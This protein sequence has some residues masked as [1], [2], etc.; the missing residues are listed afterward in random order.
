[1]NPN[2]L[3]RPSWVEIDLDAAA[4]NVAV[5]RRL[6]GATVK[7]Y[8]V[9]KA[10]AMGCGLVPIARTLARSGVDALAVSDPS[11]VVA[12]R[13][14]G[15]S[16]PVLLFAST[17][18]EQAADVAALDVIPAI[19][20]FPSLLAFAKLGRPLEVFFKIDSGMGRLGFAEQQWEKV[21]AAAADVPQL[22]LKGLYTHMSKPDDR[23]ITADQAA[24][25][26]RACAVAASH[27]FHSF[28]RLAASSRVVL[29]YPEYH[30]SA[31]DPGRLLLGMLDPPWAKMAP[32]RPVVRALKSRVI[33]VQQHPPGA[34][35]G[36]GYGQ[37]IAS[38]QPLRT[39]VI[40]VGFSDGLN[41]AP[42][43]GEVLVSGERACVLGRRSIE[44]SL[45]DVTGIP[46]VEV[47]SEV[48]LLGRQGEEEI[49]ASELA[50]TLGLPALE[51]LP[52]IAHNTSRV[53]IGNDV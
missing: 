5:A 20:D 42:P 49:T 26:E 35:L 22:R 40:P 51:L 38:E 23:E 3:A 8:G 44:F 11:D 28:E 41:H 37:P 47:G 53:F 45:L 27:G 16:L 21:F 2:P 30:Y 17:L 32:T 24:R 31:V 52:R 7:L 13:E 10:D 50:D 15:V 9:C 36:I 14:A 1:V 46:N 19:H 12:L 33:Q 25:F 39:A 48:V 4:H 43:L 18:P 29:G 34:R 6:I